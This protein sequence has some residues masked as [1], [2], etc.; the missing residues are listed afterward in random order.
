VFII[1]ELGEDGKGLGEAEFDFYFGNPGD[2]PFIGDFNGDGID[3]IG[4]Y[5]ESTGFVYLTNTLAT[6]NADLA[7]FY[8]NPGDQIL[9][10]D[11][12]GDGDDTVGV[13]RPSSGKAFLNLENS[14]GA[15][16][17]EAFVGHYPWVITA[18]RG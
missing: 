7:F 9:A 14:N 10:G 15:A 18:G 11:W 5:R 2:T 1:N 4:L 3:T 17:W 8:G 13:Y 6:G 12:D 16:D